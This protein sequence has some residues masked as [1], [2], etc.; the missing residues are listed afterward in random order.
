VLKFFSALAILILALFLQFFAA[1]IGW[2]F[3]LALAALIA[4]AFA[5]DDFWEVLVADLLAVLILNWQPAISGTLILFALIPL[6]AFAFR[7]LIHSIAWIGTLAAIIVGF[8][9]FY[10]FTAGTIFLPNIVSFLA[11]VIVGAVAGE[12][13]VFAL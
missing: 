11:D 3:N 9:A 1:S 8:S 10:V 7:K 2:H 6:A 12:L 5:L 4:F 13:I